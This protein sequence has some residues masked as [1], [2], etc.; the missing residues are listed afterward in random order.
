MSSTSIQGTT[1]DDSISLKPTTDPTASTSPTS[2]L[3]SPLQGI[4][5]QHMIDLFVTPLISKEIKKSTK[6]IT[7]GRVIITLDEYRQKLIEKQD[8]E[9][10][11][12][13]KKK[14]D[15]KESYL[16]KI[17]ELVFQQR[18]SSITKKSLLRQMTLVQ[19]RNHHQ[20]VTISTNAKYATIST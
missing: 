12:K 3:P 4:V 10:K 19:V 13:K 17:A 14:H 1:L 5:P 6:V 8:K 16:V 9:R 20:R 2:F 11:T 15:K 18:N 7:T